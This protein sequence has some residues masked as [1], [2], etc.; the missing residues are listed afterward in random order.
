MISS[1]GGTRHLYF[2]HDK[3]KSLDIYNEAKTMDTVAYNG[4]AMGI[5]YNGSMFFGFNGCVQDTP[6][7]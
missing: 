7:G 2:T 4:D 6:V 3:T 1:G 5:Q